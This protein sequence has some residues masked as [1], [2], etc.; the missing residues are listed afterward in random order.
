[1][2]P[3]GTQGRTVLVDIQRE[4]AVYEIQTCKSWPKVKTNC[5]TEEVVSEKLFS[6]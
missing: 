4:L 6:F 2:R 5:L 3:M 1:M